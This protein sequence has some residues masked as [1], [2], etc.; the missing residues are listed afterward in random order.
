M[1]WLTG[2]AWLLVVLALVLGGVAIALA[3]WPGSRRDSDATDRAHE[4]LRQRLAAGEIDEHEHRERAQVLGP[5]RT[6]RSAT[7]RWLPVALVAVVVLVLAA[8]VAAGPGMAGSGWWGPMGGHMGGH[9]GQR[10]TDGSAPAAV[11]D[12]TEF[13]V[14]A[15]EMWFDPATIE[16]V[17]GDAFN[18]TVENRGEVFHD[19]TIDALD[20]QIDVDA[21]ESTTAGLEIAEAGEY[22]FY[23]SVPGHR[24]AGMQ[25]TLTVVEA[26]N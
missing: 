25:G 20:L 13:T 21:G 14:E 3:V 15:G 5:P 24:S 8:L 1:M 7:G 12:A 6:R 10:S 9:M 4:V 23:C 17:A 26:S 11:P 22:E 18:L 2:T 19:L 16:V